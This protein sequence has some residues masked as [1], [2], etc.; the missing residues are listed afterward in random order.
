MNKKILILEPSKTT[1]SF[2]NSKFTDTNYTAFFET[3]GLKFLQSINNI[4]PAAILINAKCVNPKTSELVR[5][6]KSTDAL[7]QIPLAV[8]A[9]SDFT[10]ENAYMTNTGADIFIHLE[11]DS[12]V[13]QIDNLIILSKNNQLSGFPMEC[14]I[15][16]WDSRS[17]LFIYKIH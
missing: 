12:I 11:T 4:K 13:E 9:T 1:Q 6:I 10:F 15:M 3:D 7:R 14:D 2:L 5:L 17:N 8:Y 16:K